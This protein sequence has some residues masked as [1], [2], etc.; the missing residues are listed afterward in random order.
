ML[1]VALVSD[2]YIYI[3]VSLYWVCIIFHMLVVVVVLFL[4]HI[5]VV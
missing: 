3:Y 2:I 4:K 1:I 5:T